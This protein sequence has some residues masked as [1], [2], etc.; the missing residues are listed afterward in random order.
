MMRA[1]RLEDAWGLENIRPV[2]LPDPEPGPGELL[3][4]IEA[5]SINPRDAILMKG[6]YGRMGG[7]PPLVP[8]CDGAGRVVAMG[9][10][11]E[12]FAVGDFVCPHYSRTW[13]SGTTTPEKQKGA[14]GGPLDGT[15]RELMTVPAVAVSKAPK[16]MTA[17]EAASLPCAALTAWNAV[18]AE[19]AVGEGDTVLVQGTGGVAL[20]A[21]EIAKMRGAR[22]ILTS[23]SDEKLDRGRALGADETINYR[24]DPDWHKTARDMTDG[25]GIDLVI[26]VGGGDTLDKSVSAV[27]S[28]G[29]VALIGVLGGTT[30]PLPLGKIVTRHVRLQGVTC[31][32]KDLL[33]DLCAA[34]EKHETRP[35]LHE[36]RFDFEDLPGALAR[37]LA[38]GHFG[39]VVCSL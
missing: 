37:L 15:A 26:D 3:I 39:K 20:F 23:S 13:L 29:T 12:G 22:V 35:A 6:G 33:D 14:H 8:L 16:H 2:T 21:L 19:G 28:S 31:G 10:G 30:V 17:E 18:V 32:G 25:A 5:V 7:S 4:R 9:D 11:V 34:F 27:R 24:D 1:M 38:G 36:T